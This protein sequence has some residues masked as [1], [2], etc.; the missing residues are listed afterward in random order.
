MISPIL[1]S[2]ADNTYR[3][4]KA[5]LW[6]FS[7]VVLLKMVISFNCIFS[8]Y[9]VATSADGIPL[10]TF[11]PAGAQAVVSLFATWGLAQLVL[12]ALCLL[13]L[14]RYRA[15]VPLMFAVL[16]LEHLSRKVILVFVPI[17]TKGSTAGNI[18]NL[19]LL[20]SMV[21]GL[22][23]SFMSRVNSQVQA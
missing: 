14:F 2:R 21:I 17:E 7:F 11:T 1:P 9:S 18:V 6:L 16:L 3:G 15:L 5:A 20:C 8:G 22:V 19:V 13:A 4:Y 12:C 23:L 10:E